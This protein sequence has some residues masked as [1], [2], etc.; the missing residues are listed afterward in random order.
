MSSGEPNA[1][2]PLT[3]ERLA[4]T[5]VPRRCA[6]AVILPRGSRPQYRGVISFTNPTLFIGDLREEMNIGEHASEQS[7][8]G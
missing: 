3:K 5:L 4:A 7:G 8:G 1:N 6:E 2:E